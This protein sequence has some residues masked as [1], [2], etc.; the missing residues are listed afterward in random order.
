M[1]VHFRCEECH[2]WYTD[3][4]DH[5][6]SCT[7]VAPAKPGESLCDRCDESFPVEMLDMDYCPDCVN[8]IHRVMAGDFSA[9]GL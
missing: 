6:S 7:P 4:D 5:A 3:S 2:Q 1:F 8:A 9:Y